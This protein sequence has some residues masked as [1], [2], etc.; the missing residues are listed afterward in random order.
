MRFAKHREHLLHELCYSVPE[1][2]PGANTLLAVA[3]WVPLDLHQGSADT[4]RICQTHPG[5][6]DV[7]CAHCHTY[8]TEAGLL[9]QA[10][11]VQRLQPT[12]RAGVPAFFPRLATL[13]P[14]HGGQG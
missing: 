8:G 14:E 9:H 12:G 10:P 6:V 3:P 13:G 1:P 2:H 5:D 7:E 4:P 11:H